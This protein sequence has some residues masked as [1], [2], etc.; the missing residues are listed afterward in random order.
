MRLQAGE[1]K[2]AGEHDHRSDGELTVRTC[3]PSLKTVLIR[4]VVPY[5]INEFTI[6]I[7]KHNQA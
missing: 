7:L 3:E 2:D 1:G 4:Y 6:K 5:L